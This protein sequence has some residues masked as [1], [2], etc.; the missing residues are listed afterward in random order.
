[1]SF[2]KCFQQQFGQGPVKNVFSIG[3]HTVVLSVIMW[4]CVQL[5]ATHIFHQ[6]KDLY[7]R[8]GMFFPSSPFASGH[9]CAGEAW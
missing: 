8:N 1:M 4:S 5:S 3:H 2:L 7:L 6:Q 9:P